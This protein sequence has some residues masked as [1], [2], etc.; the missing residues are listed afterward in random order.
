MT[1]KPEDRDISVL[2]CRCM[3]H[4]STATSTWVTTYKMMISG[5]HKQ[6]T[7]IRTPDIWLKGRIP[8]IA[9]F[10]FFVRTHF[11]KVCP[12]RPRPAQIFQNLS[13]LVDP[14][15]KT[16]IFVKPA[17]FRY[18]DGSDIIRKHSDNRRRWK[19][20]A[21]VVGELIVYCWL[22][23]MSEIPIYFYHF[24]HHPSSTL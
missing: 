12:D 4:L 1:S 18:L 24:Y 2:W 9:N 16:P 23:I 5:S 20:A 6:P 14:A 22:Y 13:G 21:K 10:R 17:V 7:I 19:M 3:L 15:S 11:R 8:K